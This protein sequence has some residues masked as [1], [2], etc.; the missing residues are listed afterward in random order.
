MICGIFD[1]PSSPLCANSRN[2]HRGL[3]WLI[4]MPAF[5]H[6]PVN[7]DVVDATN[8]KCPTLFHLYDG[9]NVAN[10]LI[11]TVGAVADFLSRHLEAL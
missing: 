8:E 6:T 3:L 11:E 10:P 1:T 7:A 5:D 9:L 4:T 2:P